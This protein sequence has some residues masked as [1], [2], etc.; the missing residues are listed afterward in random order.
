MRPLT[1]GFS[2][3]HA[4][5]APGGTLEVRS[6]T[7]NVLGSTD[8][9]YYALSANGTELAHQKLGTPLGTISGS[10]EQAKAL[11]E[12]GYQLITLISDSVLISRVGAETMGKFTEAFPN[13]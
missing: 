7:L 5:V 9:Y 1:I 13:R 12:R 11:Y 10:F 6:G 8:E 2:L 4:E 3:A